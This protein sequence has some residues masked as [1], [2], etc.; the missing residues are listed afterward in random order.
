MEKVLANKTTSLT[1]L[2]E[3]EKVL[4]KAGNSPVAILNHSDVVSYF[5]PKSAMDDTT[6]SFATKE[7]KQ[8]TL[9]QCLAD[10]KDLIDYLRDK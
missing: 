10:N 4:A 2:R 8:E 1:E 7:S 5:A 6:L 3:P 9:E